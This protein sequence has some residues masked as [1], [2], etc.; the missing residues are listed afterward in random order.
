MT[1]MECRACS[2]TGANRT[3]DDVCS[4]CDGTG[5]TVAVAMTFH[6][7]PRSG[8]PMRIE[9]FTSDI[10]KIGS[11]DSNNLRIDG[12]AR[13]HAMIEAHG[14]S[15]VF[16]IDLGG[17]GGVVVNGTRAHKA[18]LHDNDEIKL[19]AATLIIHFDETKSAPG[20]PEH[21]KLAAVQNKSQ[22]I[23]EFLDS[24]RERGI[25]LCEVYKREGRGYPR[26]GEYTPIT[27]SLEALL[28]DF[29]EIDLK[30]LGAEKDA[31]L[32]AQRELNKKR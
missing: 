32:D 23:G 4:W 29:F 5:E 15:A 26:D 31:M 20:Y 17:A 3:R 9:R 16:I 2:G 24:L 14:P 6:V 30:K 25:Q 18:E 22:A 11:L 28:A 27:R 8:D 12:I 21:E 13:M 19:G 7:Q 1:T 10:V